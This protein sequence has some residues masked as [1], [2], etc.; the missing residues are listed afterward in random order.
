MLN[1]FKPATIVLRTPPGLTGFDL[2]S[3]SSITN[4]IN[5]VLSDLG[6]SVDSKPIELY[7]TLKIYPTQF[8]VLINGIPKAFNPEDQARLLQ[9]GLQNKIDPLMIQSARWLQDPNRINKEHASVVLYLSNKEVSLKIESSGLFINKDFY[10]R[11]HYSK[12]TTQCYECWKIGHTALCDKS[13]NNHDT[14]TC[15]TVNTPLEQLPCI[16]CDTKA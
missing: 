4:M 10:H 7:I 6:A 15:T 9:L 13:G 16:M 3:P 1:E 2:V 14:T 12:K 8:P 11:S 5:K